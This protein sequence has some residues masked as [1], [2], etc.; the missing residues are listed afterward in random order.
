MDGVSTVT[1]QGGQVPEYHIVPDLARLQNS[2]VTLTDLVNSVQSS[3][4]IDSPGLYEA[5]HQ[6]ILALV[7]AQA[8][9]AQQLASLV[10][11]TT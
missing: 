1:V 11:K 2:G 10:V 8:H 3:N 4:I 7:G 6:L 5:N 9:D